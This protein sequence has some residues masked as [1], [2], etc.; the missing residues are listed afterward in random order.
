MSNDMIIDKT[1]IDSNGRFKFRTEYLPEEDNLF[2]IHISRRSD[3]PVSLIIGSTDENYKF[4]IANNQSQIVIIDS[5][6]QDFI[7]DVLFMGYYPNIIIRQIDEIANYFDSTTFDGSPIKIE[8]IK[9]SISEK[10][11]AIADTCSNSLVS[12]YALNKSNYEKNYLTN[13]QYYRNFLSKW[14]KEKSTYYVAFRKKIPSTN[15][16]RMSLIILIGTLTFIAGFLISLVWF[17][18]FK[19][20]KNLLHDLSIQERKVFALILEGKSNKEMSEILMIGISTVKTHLNSIYSKLD[21]NSR[22][23]ILNL[24]LDKQDKPNHKK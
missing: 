8:L 4:V 16:L 10:L 12:L 18:I 23:E 19:K 15:N 13:Q 20:N 3:P 1:E 14:K 9:S 2:R 7:K 17:K 5:S 11:R 6:N 21:I 22:K 24:D